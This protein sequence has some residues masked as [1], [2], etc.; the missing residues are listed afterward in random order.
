MTEN[1]FINWLVW[2]LDRDA[3]MYPYSFINLSRIFLNSD[4]AVLTVPA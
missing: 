1:F 4:F 2:L 3:G